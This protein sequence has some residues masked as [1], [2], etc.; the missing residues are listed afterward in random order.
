M[1][2]SSFEITCA[3]TPSNNPSHIMYLPRYFTRSENRAAKMGIFFASLLEYCNVFLGKRRGYYIRRAKP[4]PP[5]EVH[6]LAGAFLG[7]CALIGRGF[8]CNASK[9]KVAQDIPFDKLVGL[10]FSHGS[11]TVSYPWGTGAI[12]C[13][14]L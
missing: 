3:D 8:C 11:R 13:R 9:K 12:F 2:C 6:Y 7:E 1:V 4:G 10:Y 5:W 14:A